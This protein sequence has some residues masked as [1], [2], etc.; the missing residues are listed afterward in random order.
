MLAKIITKQLAKCDVKG[1]KVVA[2][3]T[4]NGHAITAECNRWSDCGRISKWTEHAEERL[5]RK[6]VRTNTL[7]RFRGHIGVLVLRVTVHGL[8]MAR[9]CAQCQL[10]LQAAGINRVQYS[11]N[12]GEILWL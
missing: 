8:K 4:R 2:I 3:A 11:N 12:K 10:L 7:N 1:F 5:I 6:L 9:P